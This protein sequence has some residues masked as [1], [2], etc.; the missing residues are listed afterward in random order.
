MRWV[1][2][3]CVLVVGCDRLFALDPLPDVAKDGGGDGRDAQRDATEV[4]SDV[5]LDCPGDFTYIASA[6]SYYKFVAM[7]T[8]WYAAR[9]LQLGDS[10]ADRPGAM[11][12]ISA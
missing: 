4:V 9:T 7:T 3:A 6:H 8:D 5:P 1:A 10:R 12:A 2:L 11:G